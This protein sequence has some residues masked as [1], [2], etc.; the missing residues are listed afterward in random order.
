MFKPI[1]TKRVYEQV[2][3]Q[4]QDLMQKG[5]LRPGDKLL[6]ERELSDRLGV[7]RA[8]VREALSALDFLGVLES[9]QGEGTFIAQ[10]TEQVL[11]EHLA[12]FMTME[13]NAN[14]DLLEMRKILEAAAADLAAER[15]NSADIEQMSDA[16]AL[17]K[18]DV[19]SGALGEENDARFHRAVVEATGNKALAKTMALLS[20][21]IVQ[22]MRASR[23]QLFRK[24]GNREELYA[25]HLRVFQAIKAQDA[26]LARQA[27][28]S[29]LEFVE[30]ELLSGPLKQE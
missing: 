27:M 15:A 6:S 8:A 18:A 26:K 13:R 17:M 3:E 22:N 23:M 28:V 20:D 24:V 9:R 29:H 19:D 2:V 7:S 12:V 16:L 30:S 1:K 5:E 21:L 25:Q 14:L 11:T 10:V 4:I